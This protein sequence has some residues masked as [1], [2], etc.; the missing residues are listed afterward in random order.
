MLRNRAMLH[1][2]Q[3]VNHKKP[4]TSQLSLY[5]M[6]LHLQLN[7]LIFALWSWLLKTTLNDIQDHKDLQSGQKSR[8]I[9]HQVF[10]ITIYQNIDHLQTIKQQICKNKDEVLSCAMR[11]TYGCAEYFRGSLTTPT[12]TFPKILWAFVPMV[13]SEF[14]AP[15]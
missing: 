12:D 13:P 11:P 7:I 9:S 14:C 8:P 2:I 6:T 1:V 4:H 15:L 10:V 5:K 3:N